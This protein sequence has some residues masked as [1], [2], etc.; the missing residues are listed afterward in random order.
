MS[1]YVRKP[2]K[3]VV[4]LWS[5]GTFNPAVIAYKEVHVVYDNINKDDEASNNK[6]MQ[7]GDLLKFLINF[8]N[9]R[10]IENLYRVVNF[11]GE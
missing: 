7:R 1:S 4:Q 8:P 2:Q 10:K 11:G 6:V 9:Q 5:H 3:T